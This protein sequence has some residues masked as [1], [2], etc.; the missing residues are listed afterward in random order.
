MDYKKLAQVSG[1]VIFERSN[2]I[3]VMEQSKKWIPTFRY[4]LILITFIISGNAIYQLISG[5]MN[6]G[7]LPTI[8]II[9]AA[10]GM[11]LGFILFLVHRAK[12]K[13]DNLSPDELNMFCILDTD[14]GNLLGPNNSVL[15]P[16]SAVKFHKIFSFTSSSPDLALSWPGGKVVIAKGNYFAGG[17]KPI[18]DV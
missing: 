18:V 5:W 1:C 17:I 6:Q 9:F 7:S 10:V 12:V 11:F 8:G 4:V 16:L 13:A 15:A 3:Y 14:A 2:K